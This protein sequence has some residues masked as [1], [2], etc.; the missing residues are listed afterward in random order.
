MM[1]NEKPAVSKAAKWTGLILGGLPATLM[2][3]T[4]TIA[5]FNP[6]MT[7]EMTTKYGFP[8]S[9][10]MWMVLAEVASALL[11]LIPRTAVLGAILL[12]G[13][14]GG[15]V[16]THVRAGEPIFFVPVVVGIV[17]WIGLY[18]RDPRLRALAPLRS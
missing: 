14:L 17:F 12:T 15:A 1:T 5:L 7:A 16:V 11:Y 2:L 18:L 4:G 9:S 10:I 8:Q 6:A 3:V 13:Y